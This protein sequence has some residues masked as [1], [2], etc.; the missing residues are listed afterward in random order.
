[1][2]HCLFALFE[3]FDM[4]EE[5]H[6]GAMRLESGQYRFFEGLP[7]STTEFLVFVE[8]LFDFSK[9]LSNMLRSNSQ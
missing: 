6:E 7:N 1:M 9:D 5:L 8:G 2:K 4:L 3:V